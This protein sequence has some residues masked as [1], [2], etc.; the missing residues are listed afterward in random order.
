MNTTELLAQEWLLSQGYKNTQIIFRPNV[1]PDFVCQD[2]KRYEVKRLY[3]NKLL[4]TKDQVEVLK[5]TDIILVFDKEELKNKFL[6]KDKDKSIF[7]I[8]IY[9]SNKGISTIRVSK[10]TKARLNKFKSHPRQSDEEILDL[11]LIHCEEAVKRGD[12]E[13]FKQKGVKKK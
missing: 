10:Q 13:I 5:D 12:L 3:G 7:N 4:F 8:F 1:S 6:W 2:G 9:D 11:L